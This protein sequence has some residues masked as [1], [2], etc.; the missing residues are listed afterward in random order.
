MCCC[1]LSLFKSFL[2]IYIH[3]SSLDTLF[4]SFFLFVSLFFSLFF[5]LFLSFLFL[6]VI[7]LGPGVTVLAANIASVTIDKTVAGTKRC[8]CKEGFVGDKCQTVCTSGCCADGCGCLNGGTCSAVFGSETTACNCPVGYYGFACENQCTSCEDVSSS[9][10]GC[11]N[12]KFY[13]I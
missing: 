7:L 2:H 13:S 5:S 8:Q 4:F 3:F 10:C 11:S 1:Y 6:C 9:K 12:G